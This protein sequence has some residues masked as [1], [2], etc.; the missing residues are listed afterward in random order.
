VKYPGN[1]HGLDSGHLDDT[2]KI[3]FGPGKVANARLDQG[4]A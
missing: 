2:L 4:L 3:L 1:I